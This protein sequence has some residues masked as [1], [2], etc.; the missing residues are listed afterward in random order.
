M[1]T[2]SSRTSRPWGALGARPA[3]IAACAVCC[4]GPILA[5]IGGVGAVS[6]IGALWIPALAAVAVA[7][8]TG[9]LVVRRR[10]RAAA[11]RTAP[12]HADLGMPSLGPPHKGSTLAGR[13]TNSRCRCRRRELRPA[14]CPAD[15][16]RRSV[17]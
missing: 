16:R 9:I 13:E 17:P 2:P 10:Q 1:N 3:A 8:V 4:A 12:S 5:V 7:A 11:C 15:P 14:A 6:A